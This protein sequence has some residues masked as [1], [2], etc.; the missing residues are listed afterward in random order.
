MCLANAGHAWSGGG[1]GGGGGWRG[2]RHC[3]PVPWSH[4]GC[5]FFFY[6]LQT[7]SKPLWRKGETSV[8]VWGRLR[9]PFSWSWRCSRLPVPL[10]ASLEGHHKAAPPPPQLL[11]LLGYCRGQSIATAN[12]ARLPLKSA[13]CQLSQSERVKYGHWKRHR[14]APGLIFHLMFACN[15]VQY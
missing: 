4:S 10:A 14:A 9:L 13:Q 11:L 7:A 8:W 2:G 6:A 3:C 15:M 5:D 1:G 12:K